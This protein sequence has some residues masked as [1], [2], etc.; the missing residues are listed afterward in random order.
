MVSVSTTNT[1]PKKKQTNFTTNVKV[2]DTTMWKSLRL[3]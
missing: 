3:T 1:S 2:K